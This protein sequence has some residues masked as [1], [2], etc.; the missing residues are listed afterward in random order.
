MLPLVQDLIVNDTLGLT[1]GRI[2]VAA[3][4]LTVAASGIVNGGA[5]SSYVITSNG[6]NLIMHLVASATDTFQVG[7]ATNYSPAVIIANAGSVNS[8]ISVM[9]KDTVFTQGTSGVD[10]AITR[11]VVDATWFIGSSA[12]TGLN[13]NMQVM[14]SA[15]MEVNAF[16]RMNAFISHYT[17]SAWD[18]TA[19]AA[20]TTAVNGMFTISR[21]NVTS[22]SPFTVADNNS[23]LEVG[24]V[25]TA[26]TVVTIYPNPAA[27]TL[28]FTS[29]VSLT[30]AAIY[31]V[32]GRMVKS[33]SNID[34]NSISIAD[35]AP[36]YYN[37]RLYGRDNS[38]VANFIKE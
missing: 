32:S 26:N 8:D 2:N 3:H 6:G 22:L 31:D 34:N 21:N 15:A 20:A 19:T 13:L 16:D 38:S 18:V 10:A 37:V 35:L 17:N 33:V 23:K 36:G 12:G 27:N 28:N 9:V 29:T 30:G 14:W 7:S 4:N 5:A 11:P 1:A 25:A 24:K